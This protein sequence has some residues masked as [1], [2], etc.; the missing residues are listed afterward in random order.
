[1]DHVSPIIEGAQ[2]SKCKRKAS[3][4][5]GDC[6]GLFFLKKFKFKYRTLHSYVVQ[7]QGKK[8][9][10]EPTCMLN[11]LRKEQSLKNLFRL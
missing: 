6:G 5:I 9:R 1:M 7:S 10:Q 8:L 3:G 11:P 2:D 4:H